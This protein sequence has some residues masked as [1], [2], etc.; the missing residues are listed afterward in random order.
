[1]EIGDGAFADKIQLDLTMAM[2][3]W[4]QMR[5]AQ[6]CPEAETILDTGLAHKFAVLSLHCP[7]FSA[8]SQTIGLGFGSLGYEYRMNLHNGYDMLTRAFFKTDFCA[9]P[10]F[11]RSSCLAIAV[12]YTGF[13]R[14]LVIG[15]TKDAR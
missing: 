6:P 9:N 10:M 4:H 2:G 15:I 11:C 7:Y 12:F 5:I 1:M 13:T 8:R 14:A 3:P